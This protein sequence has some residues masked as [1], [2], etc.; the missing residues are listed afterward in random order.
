[1]RLRKRESLVLT[2]YEFCISTLVLKLEVTMYTI[3][4]IT[5]NGMILRLI[6]WSKMFV[7]LDVHTIGYVPL[8]GALPALQ[9]FLC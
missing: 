6:Q 2:S 9:M 3:R 8:L 5:L 7:K 1:M 4:D